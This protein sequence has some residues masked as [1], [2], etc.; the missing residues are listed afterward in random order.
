MPA[1]VFAMLRVNNTKYFV[2]DTSLV[3]KQLVDYSE[4]VLGQPWFM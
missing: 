2:V 1:M 3:G 4:M